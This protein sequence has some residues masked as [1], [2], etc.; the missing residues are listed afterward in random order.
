[1]KRQ[2]AFLGFS[3]FCCRSMKVLE[4]VGPFLALM[5]GAL[6]Y[7][8]RSRGSIAGLSSTRKVFLLVLGEIYCL[9]HLLLFF[10]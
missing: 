2:R 9:C 6:A 4:S 1:M 10:V 5:A 8:L 7:D 3:G